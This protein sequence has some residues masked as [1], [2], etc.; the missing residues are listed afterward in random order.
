[1]VRIVAIEVATPKLAKEDGP[2]EIDMF[3]QFNVDM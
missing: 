2:L 1:M 3:P